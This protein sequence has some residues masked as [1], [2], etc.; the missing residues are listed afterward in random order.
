[1]RGG[2]GPELL[3]W[4]RGREQEMVELLE[5]LVLAESPSQDPAAQRAPFSILAEELDRVGFAV[6]RIPGFDTGD[7]LYARPRA[8][9]RGAPFQLIVGHMD[10]VW[11][12]GTVER[13]PLR[14]EGDVLFG[15]GTHDMKA[16]LAQLVFA[17]QALQAF[18]LTPAVTPVAVVNSDEEIGSKSSQRVIR[19][20][21]RR[22]ERA[23]VLE[24]GEQDQNRLKI[25]RKGAGRFRISVRGRASHVGTSFE[26]GVSAILELSHQVQLLFALN[27]PERG[28]TVN[29]GTVDGGLLPN[30]VAPEA[31]ASIGVRV[32][33]A[34][35]AAEVERAIRGLRPVLKGTSL[36]IEGRGG[37]PPM[38]PT[39]RNRQLL[40]T[41]QRLGMLLDLELEDAGLAGGASD[42]NTT[43]LYTATLDGLGP[44]G[45][46]GH[47]PDEHVSISSIAERAALLAL[48]LLEPARVAGLQA[49]AS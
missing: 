44:A 34:A 18:E 40:V 27:D 6:R 32:P 43:S 2:Q 37:R 42:A 28:I 5:R 21:A 31:S 47:A 36:E 38:E 29:V 1:M 41:A 19:E 35:A 49:V 7:H 46:G 4:L 17:L 33:T 45:D 8:R 26:E 14:R 15:P 22:A 30:V 24:G 10:T 13:M 25:A 39:R 11:P 20:L 3:T 9:R 48:L 23:F 12:L 16:G